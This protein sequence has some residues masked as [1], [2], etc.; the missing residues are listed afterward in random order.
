MPIIK[1]IRD[2]ICF[3]CKFHIDIP[4]IWQIS[5]SQRKYT[6]TLCKF[7]TIQCDI[8]RC[9]I[10]ETCSNFV[11]ISLIKDTN[12]IICQKCKESHIIAINKKIEQ[13]S[14]V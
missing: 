7:C 11:L 9:D 12:M 13:T 4:K 14:T 6:Y 8:C 5:D 1:G 2:I 10:I 3:K